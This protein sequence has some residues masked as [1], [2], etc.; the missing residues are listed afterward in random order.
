MTEQDL[1]L[2]NLKLSREF[3]LYLIEHPDVAERIPANALIVLLPE[4]D[5]EL[6]A[7]NQEL[8]RVRREPDQ[9]IVSVRVGA[10]T[11]PR[12]RLV[13]PTVEVAA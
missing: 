2:K 4:D 9:P 10:L 12:S 5:P 6:C 8:A 1:F 7:K 13:N 11:P 3:D